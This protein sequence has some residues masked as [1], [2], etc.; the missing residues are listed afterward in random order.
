LG[1]DFHE[2][3]WRGGSEL[4]GS[5]KGDIQ[6]LY[7]SRSWEEAREVIDRYQ[8]SYIY[9]GWLE[10]TT[11]SPISVDKFE[12]NMQTIYQTSEVTIY[13]MPDWSGR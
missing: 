4:Q 10:E 9:V 12:L 6:R 11:Y 1:W 5:R 7:Q 13:A 8:I 3:Q 2:I